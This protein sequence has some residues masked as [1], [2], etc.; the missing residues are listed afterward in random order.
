MIVATRVAGG[1]TFGKSVNRTVSITTRRKKVNYKRILPERISKRGRIPVCEPFV[2]RLG[3]RY[4]QIRGI[5]E[6]QAQQMEK[7][8]R[9]CGFLVYITLPEVT[10]EDDFAV[11]WGLR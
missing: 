10:G 2:E 8:M 11:T 4:E 9:S 3:E 1:L 5:T 7:Q 6:D